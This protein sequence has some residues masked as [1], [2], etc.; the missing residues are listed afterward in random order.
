MIKKVLVVC[1]VALL[2]PCFSYIYLLVAN[3]RVS[4]PVEA[5]QVTDSLEQSTQWLLSNREH[6]LEVNNSMLWWMVKR[7]AEMTRD[8]RLQLLYRDYKKK[9]FDGN[10]STVWKALFVPFAAVSI[11]PSALGYLPDYNQY[12]IYG[13]TCNKELGESALI[14]SQMSSDFCRQ[15][16][17]IS[18]ACVTHQLMGLRFR[19]DRSCGDSTEMA[20]QVAE[21][22]AMIAGQL[23]W[24]PRVVDVYIQRVLM[25][26]DTGARAQ[27]KDQWLQQLLAAQL[28]DG[29]WADFESLLQLTDNLHIG[30]GGR[31][32]KLSQPKG[33]F[34][35]TAQGV[36]L[37]SLLSQQSPR[38]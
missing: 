16:H 25:L 27:V 7:S 24:D 17:P 5:A 10:Y 22:Q 30:F 15:H 33:G 29:S 28:D 34:H 21:L 14:Q 13:L 1:V 12:F 26:V 36:L 19:Q 23:Y 37:M 8:H 20:G 18:P 32:I 38:L 4:A 6:I 2:I 35:A 31:G 3:N 11:N 9:Y